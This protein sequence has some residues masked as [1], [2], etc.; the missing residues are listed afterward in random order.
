Q[1]EVGAMQHEDFS[2]QSLLLFIILGASLPQFAARCLAFASFKTVV[3]TPDTVIL[4]V[5]ALVSTGVFPR[6][7]FLPPCRKSML[8]Q[9]KSRHFAH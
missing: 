8:I 6:G 5:K 2:G 9:R 1:I 7:K 3:W 4:R